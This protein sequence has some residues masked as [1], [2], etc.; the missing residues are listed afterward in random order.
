MGINER[1]QIEKAIKALEKEKINLKQIESE[2]V[3]D[4]VH[5]ILGQFGITEG[6]IKRVLGK[7]CNCG[8]RRKLLNRIFP[9]AK[10]D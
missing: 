6:L 8:G 7:S 2:G 3:G 10:K 5:K 1:A 9:Y 4:T